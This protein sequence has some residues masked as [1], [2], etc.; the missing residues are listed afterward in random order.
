MELKHL[1][2]PIIFLVSLSECSSDLKNL[3]K[4]ICGVKNI[5]TE[6]QGSIQNYPWLVAI[7][8]KV[9][10]FT[11][12]HYNFYTGTLVSDQFVVTAANVFD[13]EEEKR[14]IDNVDLF[15][16]KP[17]AKDWE[18]TSDNLVG[19]R[20]IEM[21]W[22]HPYFNKKI[23][24]GRGLAYNVALLKLKTRIIYFHDEMAKFGV[25]PICLPTPDETPDKTK[26]EN[27]V[28]K[29]V[30]NARAKD[31]PAPT[32]AVGKGMVGNSAQCR[33]KIPNMFR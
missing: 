24:E 4:C 8:R 5:D 9:K 25:R 2:H 31:V 6:G 28:G 10:P 32:M 18:E 3:R 19:W 7:R 1:F 14:S 26:L 22:I 17:G 12:P 30:F 15:E 11:S 33:K 13:H 16:A 21:I 29:E 20:P 23:L 27:L